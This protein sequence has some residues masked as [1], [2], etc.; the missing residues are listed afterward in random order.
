ML[1]CTHKHTQARA[2]DVVL[3]AQAHTY[4][5]LPNCRHTLPFKI[6]KPTLGPPSETSNF[7][8]LVFLRQCL[9]M[10]QC[11]TLLARMPQPPGGAGTCPR[12]AHSCWGGPRCPP[13]DPALI[14]GTGKAWLEWAHSSF[15]G[16][17]A[18][19]VVVAPLL[20]APLQHWL[21]RHSLSPRG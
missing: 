17:T 5:H 9:H 7:F 19:C 1:C 14:P 6:V 4:M 11:H 13:T 18:L 20:V 12:G 2:Q 21:P 16:G 3:H 10:T 15:S 8:L